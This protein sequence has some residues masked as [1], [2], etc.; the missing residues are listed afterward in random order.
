MGKSTEAVHI[1]QELK[2]HFPNYWILLV[3]MGNQK[4]TEAFKENNLLEFLK[5]F[6][7]LNI[8]KFIFEK[9]YDQGKVFAILDAYDE[10]PPNKERKIE[11][12][13]I[14]FLN[15]NLKNRIYITSRY[16]FLI[17]CE[18]R[19]EETIKMKNFSVL[20]LKPIDENQQKEFLLEYFRQ[21]LSQKDN[22]Q[23]I[24]ATNINKLL[25]F[26]KSS[27][28][29]RN[30]KFLGIPLHTFMLAQA[31]ENEMID[32]VKKKESLNLGA[33]SSLFNLFEK[34]MEIKFEF[35]HKKTENIK[36]LMK[37][38]L[39]S[40]NCLLEF[41]F[42]KAL[43]LIFGEG[44]SELGLKFN[45]NRI[46]RYETEEGKKLAV[47]DG[48][49]HYKNDQFTFLHRTYAEYF[50]ALAFSEILCG[51]STIE[52]DLEKFYT[53]FFT[54]IIQSSDDSSDGEF[55]DGFFQ[56]FPVVCKFLNSFL[57]QTSEKF[58]DSKVPPQK[59]IEVIRKIFD[60]QITCGLM[61]LLQGQHYEDN[62]NLV[63][64]VWKL[65][66][67]FYND[68]RK[69]EILYVFHNLVPGSPT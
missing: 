9:L 69:S 67:D 40:A 28:T 60:S 36:H 38:N 35:L 10:I 15:E 54:E 65:Y 18:K 59:D 50:V 55:I 61:S 1:A 33:D 31:F 14:I 44:F 29:E 64:L 66:T 37:S 16:D 19:D 21:K 32:A 46:N 30:F 43:E 5:S 57:P 3:E 42:K 4:C 49:V 39:T 53:F 25:K 63:D 24:L 27:I 20:Q 2:I 7:N 56:G 45:Q 8:E 6:V 62:D 34:F 68:T 48:F 51:T 22:D 11:K 26:W 23:K 52:V 13:L 41:Y 58:P 12:K 17:K 47:I